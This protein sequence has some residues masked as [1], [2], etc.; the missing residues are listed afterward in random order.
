MSENEPATK[1]EKR[2]SLHTQLQKTKSWFI[3]VVGSLFSVVM[4]GFQAAQFLNTLAT[5]QQV[6]QL[7]DQVVSENVKLKNELD[8]NRTL[9]SE[10]R[11]ELTAVKKAFVD[12][13]EKHA[14]RLAAEREPNRARAAQTAERAR[15]KF[16]EAIAAGRSIEQ[17]LYDSAPDYF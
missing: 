14:G 4:I 13:M 12:H 5:K 10:M 7:R 3:L 2:P 11:I 9:N 1:P 16:R 15:R 8:V 6:E 17:A